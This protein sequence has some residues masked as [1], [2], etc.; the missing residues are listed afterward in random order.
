EDAENDQVFGACGR[1]DRPVSSKRDT[2][3]DFVDAVAATL[4]EPARGDELASRMHL[5]PARL[6]RSV[7]AAAGE[8][9]GQLRRRILLERAAFRLL[10]RDLG[11]LEVALE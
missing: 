8:P 7:P 2:L 9:P 3:V 10:E 5:S 6:A 1:Q 4:D 11:I